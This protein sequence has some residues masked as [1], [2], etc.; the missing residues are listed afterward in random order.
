MTIY[1]ELFSSVEKMADFISK[2]GCCCDCY[3]C[4]WGKDIPCFRHFAMDI[5]P[6]MIKAWLLSEQ[7]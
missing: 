5:S 1:D 3:C 4:V 2:D 7:N 6:E